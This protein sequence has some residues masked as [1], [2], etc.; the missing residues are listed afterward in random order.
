LHD[1]TVGDELEV[2]ILG[3]DVFQDLAL[4]KGLRHR[5]FGWSRFGRR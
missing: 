5:R 4:I 1:D 2:F 3:G